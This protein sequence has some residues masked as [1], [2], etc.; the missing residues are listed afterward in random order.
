M[1]GP[2][3][4]TSAYSSGLAR[5]AGLEL[6]AIG[7]AE[8]GVDV[9]LAYADPRG[10]FEV[11][12]GGAAAAVEADVDVDRVADTSQQFE[13]ELLGDRVAAVQV[14]DRCRERCRFPSRRRTRVP[15]RALR[16][17]CAVSS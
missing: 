12:S 9:D 17:S 4:L 13:V 6:R 16:T 7:V 3:S 15:A 14:P 2:I 11:V 1:T 8:V 10:L 5:G